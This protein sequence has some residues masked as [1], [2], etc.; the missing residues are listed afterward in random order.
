[1]MFFCS[2]CSCPGKYVQSWCL[3]RFHGVDTKDEMFTR[4][5]DIGQ[6]TIFQKSSEINR[7]SLPASLP[8][9]ND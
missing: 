5:A 6:L 3:L 9:L 8:N 1:M 2:A 4:K 7:E